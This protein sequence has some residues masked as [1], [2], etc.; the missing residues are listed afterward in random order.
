[1][2]DR[3]GGLLLAW[4]TPAL[5]GQAAL[6]D[7]PRVPRA[8]ML[9]KDREDWA[10]QQLA[11]D[12]DPDP[13]LPPPPDGRPPPATA[14]DAGLL[15][16]S[17]EM[18]LALSSRGARRTAASRLG[19]GARAATAL[20]QAAVAAALHSWHATAQGAEG[21]TGAFSGG[22]SA[23][24]AGKAVVE[25]RGQGRE[26]KGGAGGPA[27]G[28]ALRS[29][30]LSSGA[31]QMTVT[32]GRWAEHG[33]QPAKE[34]GCCAPRAG[35]G[36]AGA[37]EVTARSRLPPV[38]RWWAPAAEQKSL[39]CELRRRRRRSDAAA[40][41]M[42]SALAAQGVQ[43]PPPGT[44]SRCVV[45]NPVYEAALAALEGPSMR[46]TASSCSGGGEGA[47]G[48]G[49]GEAK[50]Q[51][52]PLAAAAAAA[53]SG[54][55]SSA[56]L[57]SDGED[58]R[59]GR[60]SPRGPANAAG[61][62]RSRCLA[63]TRPAAAC[64]CA[65]DAALGARHVRV[66]SLLLQSIQLQAELGHGM[67]AGHFSL[68]PPCP[69]PREEPGASSGDSGSEDGE[70]GAGDAERPWAG[71]CQQPLVMGRC[72]ARLRQILKVR[73]C[74]ACSRRVMHLEFS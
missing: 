5:L 17:E 37:R 26:A 65:L 72:N 62:R 53:L 56:A 45:L 32:A 47:G 39:G 21:T 46:R 19:P 55:A 38:L 33:S 13:W 52:V 68:L 67:P 23:A 51:R 57:S 2:S 12:D 48:G 15:L 42:G 10:R 31:G 20:A 34:S 11:A 8:Q 3:P 18:L 69:G 14:V 4:R 59:T 27:T 44:W 50:G 40:A 63:R 66:Q 58:A 70:V 7:P 73:P 25:A 49:G 64:V 61:A 9:A 16:A 29:V 22:A 36:A 35:S 24:A 74:V 60:R 1:M 54:R 43:A 28:D 30:Q 41:S 6:L 71:A